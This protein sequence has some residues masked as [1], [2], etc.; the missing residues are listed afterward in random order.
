MKPELE[1]LYEGRCAGESR[2]YLSRKPCTNNWTRLRIPLRA[3]HE[4]ERKHCNP[5]LSLSK[6]PALDSI[7]LAFLAVLAFTV[8]VMKLRAR[9]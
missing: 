5:S 6:F 4:R 7:I 2:R 9:L 8:W 3:F 1:A